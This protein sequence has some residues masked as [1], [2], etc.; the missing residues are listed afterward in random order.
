MHKDPITLLVMFKD[1]C[2][3]AEMDISGFSSLEVARE[4]VLQKDKGR[5]WGYEFTSKEKMKERRE[6]HGTPCN[7]RV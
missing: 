5:T 7:C 3:V 6:N 1:G 4:I 2:K